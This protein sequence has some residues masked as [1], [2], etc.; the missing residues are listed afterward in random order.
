MNNISYENTRNINAHI[1]YK[2]R[3]SGG[4][5]LQQLFFLSGYPSP[6][7][8]TWPAGR[9]GDGVVRLEDGLVHAI[10]IVVRDTYGNG[11]DLRFRVRYQ[12]A[13]GG[14]VIPQRQG[15]KFY[16]G[17]VDGIE[18]PDY[19]FFLGEKSLYDS[20]TIGAGTVGDPGSG[21]SLPGGVSAV[22]AIGDKWIPLLDPVLVRL[23]LIT[24][25]A[26]GQAPTPVNPIRQLPVGGRPRAAGD[27]HTRHSRWRQPGQGCPP[28]RPGER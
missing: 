25:A 15:K 13:A 11:S 27:H 6:S 1:D 21:L 23:R 2:T 20:V 16:A 22:Q 18:T 28:H 5:F 8:Y 9:H 19:A 26:N 24:P 7:I 10:H 12:P 14:P 3:E 17:M 4:P